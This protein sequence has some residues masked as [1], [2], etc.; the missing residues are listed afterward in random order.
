MVEN[1][2]VLQCHYC[3][4]ITLM[5]QV[6]CHRHNWDEGSGYYG[7]IEY[8]MFLCPV[9]NKV[10]FLQKYWDCAYN[11]FD[12]E[13][14]EINY[15]D[16]EILYPINTFKSDYLPE[17]VKKAYEAALKT[18]NIDNAICLVALR[19]TL[20]IICNEKNAAG[21]TLWHKIE[22]LSSKGILPSELQHAS[23][24]TKNYGNMGAHEDSVNIMLNELNHIIE[25]VQY[26]IDYLY[27]LPAKLNKIQQQLK[28]T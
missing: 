2:K 20:E 26:I 1:Q 18:K 19:R 7:Y 10:S 5:N 16:E 14:N 3:G 17:K 24:I 25:F 12:R 15:F 27:I 21:Q 23:R 6:G 22:D 8:L 13:G 9:C 28:K 11:G 4:N